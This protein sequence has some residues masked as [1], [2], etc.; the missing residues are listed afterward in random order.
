MVTLIPVERSINISQHCRFETSF[1]LRNLLIT[2]ILRRT[3]GLRCLVIVNYL[4]SCATRS[5]QIYWAEHLASD[6]LWLSTI[7]LIF[8]C[9]SIR[10]SYCTKIRYVIFSERKLCRS[11]R[12]MQNA[13]LCKFRIQIERSFRCCSITG[14]RHLFSCA[15]HSSQIYCAGHVASGALWM[16]NVVVICSCVSIWHHYYMEIRYLAF[17]EWKWFRSARHYR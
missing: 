10:H 7:N 15:I 6:A 17:S 12:L 16:S 14:K 8:Y 4:F 11:A 5:P 13:M 9:V 3:F 1:F 2:N